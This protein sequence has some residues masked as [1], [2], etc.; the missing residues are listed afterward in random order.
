MEVFDKSYIQGKIFLI[1][2][3][4]KLKFYSTDVISFGSI[5][6]GWYSQPFAVGNKDVNAN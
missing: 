6:R 3:T 5:D 1:A 4:T 2:E